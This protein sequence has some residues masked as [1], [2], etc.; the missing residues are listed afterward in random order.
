MAFTAKIESKKKNNK[1][2][3][4]GLEGETLSKFVKPSLTQ[5]FPL[6]KIKGGEDESPSDPRAWPE[7][8]EKGSSECRRGCCSH[9]KNLAK[10]SF[11]LFDGSFSFYNSEQRG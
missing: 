11:G 1:H 3:L 5:I 9:W 7:R 8:T 2:L 10:V 4:S 6:D